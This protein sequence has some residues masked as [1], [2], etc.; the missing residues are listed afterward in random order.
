MKLWLLKWKTEPKTPWDKV[1]AF[2]II[3]ETTQQAREIAATPYIHADEGPDV[4]L[5]PELTDCIEVDMSK[6]G[7]IV[8][9]VLEG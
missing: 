8:R 6:P 4:W 2:A 1:M 7:V 5:N 3:A 9:D